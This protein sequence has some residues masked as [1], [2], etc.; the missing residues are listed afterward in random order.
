MEMLADLNASK[1][2][3][4]AAT[5]AGSGKSART[6]QATIAALQ[7]FTRWL[8]ANGRIPRDPS[9]SIKKPN[10]DALDAANGGCSCLKSGHCCRLLRQLDQFAVG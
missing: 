9:I 3:H 1:V 5:L 8:V 2:E 4:Y 10:P 7:A 6:I